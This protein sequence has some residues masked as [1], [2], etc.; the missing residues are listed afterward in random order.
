[1]EM[2]LTTALFLTFIV[3][4][5]PQTSDVSNKKINITYK[6]LNKTVVFL[7]DG[8]FEKAHNLFLKNES[9][10]MTFGLPDDQFKVQQGLAR[11]YHALNLMPEAHAHANLSIQVLASK[12]VFAENLAYKE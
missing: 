3:A 6:E 1:M 7:M 2:L 4:A 12:R 8:R 9:A 5:F 11:I 10:V